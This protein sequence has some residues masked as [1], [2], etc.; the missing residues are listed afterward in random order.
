MT[1]NAAAQKEIELMNY[2]RMAG[3]KYALCGTAFQPDYDDSVPCN[4]R[5]ELFEAKGIRARVLR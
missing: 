3:A 1:F 5:T 2:N 4:A